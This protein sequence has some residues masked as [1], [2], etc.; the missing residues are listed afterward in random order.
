MRKPLFAALAIALAMPFATSAAQAKPN[1]VKLGD[2]DLDTD[3]GRAELEVRIRKAAN[4]FCSN[5]SQTGTRIQV[6][7]RRGIREE[8]LAR[9]E[10]YQNRVG[11]GG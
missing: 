5:S 2:L 3:A 9:V 1:E 4:H 7:C 11:K 10:E 6:T 8:I